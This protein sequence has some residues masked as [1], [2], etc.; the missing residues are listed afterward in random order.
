M[1]FPKAVL[2][3]RATVDDLSSVA[4]L[5]R[6]IWRECYRGIISSAQ[7][8]YMLDWMYGRETL[9]AGLE[10]G[11]CLDL[12]RIDGELAGFASYGPASRLDVLK[13]HKLYL[14]PKWHGCGLGSRLLQHVVREAAVIGAR[15][16]TLTVNKRNRRAIAA[17]LRNGFTIVDAVTVDIGGG[18]VMDDYVML[19][20]L[21]QKHE[22]PASL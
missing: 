18:F 4:D 16:L 6:V 11:V 21:P 14:H 7:I 13:L 12:L 2:I 8:D 9:K 10:A 22:M 19:K 1:P 17:Y 20:S 5:A 15:E 3:V